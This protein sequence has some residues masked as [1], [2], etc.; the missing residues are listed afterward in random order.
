MANV[1]DASGLRATV[2]DVVSEREGVRNGF[3]VG[4]TGPTG[5]RLRA[6]GNVPAVVRSRSR[7]VPCRLA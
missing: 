7:C 4:F 6:A 2:L 1:R 5:V 3:T